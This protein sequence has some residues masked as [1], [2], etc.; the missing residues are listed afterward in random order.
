MRTTFLSALRFAGLVL[1]CSIGAAAGATEPDGKGILDEFATRHQV[2]YEFE[3]LTVKLID[4]QGN[5]LLREMRRYSRRWEEGKYRHLVVVDEPSSVRGTALLAWQNLEGRDHQWTYLPAQKKVR[6]QSA[7]RGSLRQYF[8]GTDLSY[9]DLSAEDGDK[10]SYERQPDQTIDGVA[11]FVVRA[12][13]TDPDL[14]QES[15]YQYRDLFLRKDNYVLVR[16]DFYDTRGKFLK[17]LVAKAEPVAL[18]G[19][20]W[21]VDHFLI[22]N[23]REQH[24]TELIVRERSTDEGSVPKNMF[25][26]QYLA[27][28][29]HIE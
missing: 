5:E 2:P 3:R 25:T 8:M 28:K 29:R 18:S 15:G 10:Y 26:S 9:E 1:V 11:H 17:R 13:P 22:E 27:S 12:R 19:D 7:T 4:R 24:K 20:A 14:Q 6:K 16:V 23:E 21:R